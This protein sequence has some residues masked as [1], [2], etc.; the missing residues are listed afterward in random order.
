VSL[1]E[2]GY[3]NAGDLAIDIKNGSEKITGLPGI[4]PKTM[5]KLQAFVEKLPE[6]AAKIT[7]EPEVEAAIPESSVEPKTDETGVEPAAESTVDDIQTIKTE[8]EETP[9]EPATEPSFDDLFK[10]AALKVIPPSEDEEEEGEA[11]DKDKKKKKKKSKSRIIT[12]D[13]DLDMTIVQKKHKTGD[14]E[15]EA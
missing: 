5:E 4:G 6:L 8:T 1:S 7:P 3:T 15:W 9:V 14:E 11:E 2:A 13:P 10:A 12:Y